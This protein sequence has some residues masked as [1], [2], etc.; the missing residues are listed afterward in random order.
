MTE[1]KVLFLCVHNS[2]RS[3]MAEAWLNVANK[4]FRA[5]SAGSEPGKLNPYVVAAMGEAGIDIS[6]NSAKS[7]WD[8]YKAGKRYSYVISLCD[9]SLDAA[10]P[11]FPGSV[12][13]LH[14]PFPDPAGVEGS[15]EEKLDQ[16]RRIRD[17]IRCKIEEWLGEQEGAC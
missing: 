5:E 8:L 2:G 1:K 6:G 16:V 10:C 4:E 3:Q 15:E 12:A 13:R 17:D 9:E 7:A 11:V 14:W